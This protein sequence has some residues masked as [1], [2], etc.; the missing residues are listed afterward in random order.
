MNALIAFF[1]STT[2]AVSSFAVAALWLWRRPRSNAARRFMIVAAVAY[3]FAS[4]YAVPAF[5]TRI[6]SLGYHPFVATDTPPSPCAVVV[7]GSGASVIRGWEGRFDLATDIEASRVLETA[8]VFQ[9]IDPALVVSSGG[10]PSDTDDS[11]PSGRNMRDELIR[12]GV[13]DAR[14]VV[15]IESSNTRDE[16]RVVTPILRARGIDQ[17][18]LVTSDSHMRRALG[19][20]RAFGWKPIPAI[21]PHPN[22]NG[23]LFDRLVPS[24]A[25]LEF[26]RQ[27]IRE[28]FGLPY[29]WVRGWWRM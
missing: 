29:F 10:L 12:L 18:V 27:V 2:G 16:A 15:E 24:G 17:I 28:I 9:L 23:P 1:F 25:G 6:L 5:V 4:V 8:R 3:L 26:S 7:L 20:F 14:I 21:A 19:V 11:E 22:Y 13:P